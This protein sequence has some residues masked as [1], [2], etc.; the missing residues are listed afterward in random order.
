MRNEPTNKEILISLAEEGIELLES[1]DAAGALNCLKEL[2][3]WLSDVEIGSVKG[4]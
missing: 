1:G 3:Q 4:G 2:K